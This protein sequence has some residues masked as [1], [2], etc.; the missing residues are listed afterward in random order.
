[1]ILPGYIEY[2]NYKLRMYVRKNGITQK[3]MMQYEQKMHAAA[4]G[5]QFSARRY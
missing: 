3:K 4:G 5:Q 2:E 1:M